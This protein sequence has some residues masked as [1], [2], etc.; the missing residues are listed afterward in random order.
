MNP[1]DFSRDDLLARSVGTP[2]LV[3]GLVVAA[4]LWILS[5]RLRG[6]IAT[7]TGRIFAGFIGALVLGGAFWLL[8]QTMG[9]FLSL[10][11][12]W[13]LWVLA[14]LAGFAAETII[15]I[16]RL[17]RTLV[18]PV[19]RGRWLL[20]L[21][22]IALGILIAILLQ[23]VRSFL[24][25]RE[26]NREIAILI[27]DSESMQISDQ[28]LGATERLDRAAVLG[29]PAA[30]NRPPL[31]E[32]AR[33]L[34]A[35]RER[36]GVE[37]GALTDAPDPAAAVESRREAITQWIADLTKRATDIA[38]TLQA[39]ENRPG[40][41]N[42]VKQP[43]AELRNLLAAPLTKAATDS[44][45]R[46]AAKDPKTLAES[47]A[48]ASAHLETLTTRLPGLREGVDQHFYDQLSAADKTEIDEAA[49]RP[50][51]DIV[52]AL[53][54]GPE[55]PA[56][57]AEKE[58]TAPATAPIKQ[59]TVSEATLLD[60]L[61]E[62]YNL[63][64]YRFARD[65]REFPKAEQVFAPEAN[66]S[67]ESDSAGL[68]TA[69]DL[70]QALDHILE[71]SSPESLAGVLLL[72]DGR[73]NGPR[74]PEDSLRQLGVQNSPL[75]AVPFGGR[76]GP[77]DVSILSLAAPESIYLGDRVGVK[78]EVKFDGLRGQ[79]VK[80][81]L[82][83]GGEIVEEQTITVPDVNH[84]A[85]LRF[86]HLPEKKGI[87][88]YRLELSP[89]QGEL[90][91][92][93]NSWDF[94]IAV[95]DDRTNVL[96]VDGVPRW[97]FRYLRNLFY[98]R[99][100]SVHLQY[101]LLRPDHIEG[102]RDP[103]IVAATATRKFGDADADSLPANADEWRLFDVIILGD[104]PPGALGDT[105]WRAI[106]EA[107]TERG[108][109]LVC[110]GGPNYM[111]HAHENKVL[112]DLLPVTWD[113]SAAPRLES[114]EPAYRIS[115][116]TAGRGHPVMAQST[117][118]SVNA[119]LWAQMPS[120]TWRNTVTGV[121]EGA[122]VLAYAEAVDAAAAGPDG[123][124]NL[125]GSP[126]SVEAAIQNLANRKQFEQERALVV[127]QRA[128]LG[129]VAMLTFDQTWRLRYG[130]GDTYHH[131]FWGQL[132]RWGAGENLRSGGEQVRLGTDR[133]TYTPSDTV[134][135]VAKV[136]DAERRP[137]T[138]ADLRAVILRD[139]EPLL[140]QKMS[141][142]SGSSGI[143]ET[144]VSALPRAGEYTVRLEGD[145]VETALKAGDGGENLEAVETDIVVVPS[146]N[147]VELAELTADRDFLNHAA[148][149][150]GGKVAELGDAKSLVDSF[151]APKETLT[152]R[153]NITLWDKWPLLALFL[154]LMTTEWM[155]R[156]RSG[157][158]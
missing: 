108:A 134:E 1:E 135:I 105:E 12:S 38:A 124:I 67:G 42:E 32:A 53:L 82:R 74:L 93:N 21:R 144:S 76:L 110:I 139:G 79:Q 77:V 132:V 41:P 148:Q 117:S 126:A 17:E 20:A 30:K 121:K 15:V 11:T 10:A 69:T 64:Y 48:A 137:V 152:E 156:R 39:V 75:S 13:P 133:L 94:K 116:T 104:I 33:D 153:R 70:T 155:L 129:K 143:Y 8:F 122:E 27:D 100:K 142:R 36:L 140:K 136:L 106:R 141:Y 109:L 46:L 4:A 73:H 107:V 59:G 5:L 35:L 151:G 52:R 92:S 66:D 54:A 88:D 28:R 40:L 138:D 16:Y 84:R 154:G 68:R 18:S 9:R 127:V 24:V 23:P 22:L 111:P 113:V 130:V 83:H 115:L 150:S 147:P 44:T 62:R 63:R 26:I 146:R 61:K 51:S 125:D 103:E 123:E 47:F 97:E 55:K 90:F 50:R 43:A 87:F 34:T 95:T 86:V 57:D 119:Q 96:L 99:D 85:E 2:W 29:V 56:K 158:A 102:V 25:D 157:L 60:Q 101:V 89:M 6:R 131:R 7:R 71:N 112:K 118:R 31:G 98:G 37:Q 14:A 91:D 45:A 149:V 114:P 120:A 78:A 81:T 3:A 19:S 58:K 65:P 49:A 80:A 128:G 145:A 72:S